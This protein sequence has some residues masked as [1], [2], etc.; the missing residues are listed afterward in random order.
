MTRSQASLPQLSRIH[1]YNPQPHSH[2]PKLTIGYPLAE[3]IIEPE[4]EVVDSE[5][6]RSGNVLVQSTHPGPQPRPQG[7][8]GVGVIF[9]QQQMGVEEIQVSYMPQGVLDSAHV[10]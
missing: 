9:S 1:L 4:A 5:S 2:F 6:I 7:I 10:L 3:E 8:S